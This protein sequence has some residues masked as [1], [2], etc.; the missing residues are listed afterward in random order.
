MDLDPGQTRRLFLAGTVAF[1]TPFPSIGTIWFETG[2]L[3]YSAG[4]S[5]KVKS[6]VIVQER[7]PRDRTMVRAL[8]QQDV[9]AIFIPGL[10]EGD[11][12]RISRALRVDDFEQGAW[13][14]DSDVSAATIRARLNRS[15]ED[16][17]TTPNSILR[18]VAFVAKSAPVLSIAEVAETAAA[19]CDI[20]W[21][22]LLRSTLVVG[23]L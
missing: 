2:N 23:C 11:K 15:E 19:T 1:P 22:S 21:P 5:P 3:T 16:D 10:W 8:L 18:G 20:V 13:F 7:S 14:V 12:F 17:L 4:E 9:A 6:W